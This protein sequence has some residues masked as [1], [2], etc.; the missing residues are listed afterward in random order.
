MK[1]ITQLTGCLPRPPGYVYD[2]ERLRAMTLPGE[3][4]AQMEKTP[5]DPEWHGEGDVWTHTKKVCEALAE[6]D[7]FRALEEGPR[8]V[9]ALAALLH[10]IGKIR[11]TRQEAGRWVSPN[12]GPVGAQM[13]RTLLWKEFG[14]SG[15]SEK[16]R[17]REAVCWLIRYHTLPLHLSDKRD[18][19]AQALKLAANGELAPDFTLHAL[20]LLAEADTLG[21]IAPDL[22]DRL[23]DVEQSREVIREA[24]CMEGPYPFPSA[25]TQRALFSGSKVWKNQEMYDDSRCE[26][27]LMCGLPGTGKDTWIRENGEGLPV[28]SLDGLRKEMK[29]G[30]GEN[31]GRVVQAAREKARAYLRTGQS[32]IWN[33]TSLTSLRSQQIEL[34]EKYHARV[35]IVYLETAWEENIRRNAARKETV[36][37]AV[38]ER[39]LEKLEPP[40]RY[41][42]RQVEWIC[43]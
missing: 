6:A 5:Q 17:F 28:V 26:V 39:M 20:C 1:E 33:A 11:R 32:F 8:D 4:F 24:G 23:F 40:E 29:T 9:L 27:I 31:Q 38:L 10:D 3:W 25:C 13:A 36:P 35:R 37:E 43:V 16:Q 41:E 7:G 42:A 18:P 12:H 15:E 14:M 30:S 19:A 22:Q 34:F 21:R 2:W